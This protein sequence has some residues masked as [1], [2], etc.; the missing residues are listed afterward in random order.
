MDHGGGTQTLK[1]NDDDDPSNNGDGDNGSR[2]GKGGDLFEQ[3]LNKQASVAGG[4]RVGSRSG[5]GGQYRVL[6][7]DERTLLSLPPSEVF[8]V[9]FPTPARR[10]KYFKNMIPEI[11]IHLSPHCR[12]FFHE[13]DFEFEYLKQGH[14]PCCRVPELD[15]PELDDDAVGSGKSVDSKATGVLSVA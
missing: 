13:D 9:K 6:E 5:S 4:A 10:S 7:L 8:I 15:T 1:L 11:K 14:C 3:A 2:G 12:R